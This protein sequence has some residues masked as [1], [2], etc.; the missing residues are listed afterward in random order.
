M[1]SAVL[2]FASCFTAHRLGRNAIAMEMNE[3]FYEKAKN[4]CA[5][6]QEK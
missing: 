4:G 5:A 6:L 3:E 2:Q 1:P